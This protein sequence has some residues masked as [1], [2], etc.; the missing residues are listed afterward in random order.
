MTASER[1]SLSEIDDV[2]HSR[3]RL[4][5]MNALACS[6]PLSFNALKARLQTSDG[7][8]S[9]AL[10]KLELSGL[11]EVSKSYRERKPLTEILITEAG[12]TA[13]ERYRKILLALLTDS[14]SPT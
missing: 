9:V 7:N 4:L 5:V 2:I 1:I 11:V 6:S 13:Y 12:R 14:A 10:R 8:L 3:A